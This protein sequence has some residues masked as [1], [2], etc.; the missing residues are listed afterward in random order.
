MWTLT[1]ESFR[2]EAGTISQNCYVEGS[3]PRARRHGFHNL[4]IGVVRHWIG[5]D[6]NEMTQGRWHCTGC[7][8][9]ESIREYTTG[10]IG[11]HD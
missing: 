5:E 6:C 1:Q 9:S 7:R 11:K 3:G 10:N 4:L 8:H 2:I